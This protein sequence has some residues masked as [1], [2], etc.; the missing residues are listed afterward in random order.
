MSQVEKRAMT[1]AGL[2]P[3]AL[4]AVL[5]LL[6]IGQDSAKTR[7]AAK[8]GPPPKLQLDLIAPGQM[9]FA[10]AM[11]ANTSVARAS[12]KR[13]PNARGAVRPRPESEGAKPC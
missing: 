1:G 8:A 13:R 9:P 12:Q 3:I 7:K 11:R 5:K 4:E 6:A 10:A 2:P